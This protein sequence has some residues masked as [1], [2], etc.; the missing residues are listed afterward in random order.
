MFIVPEMHWPI[1]DGLSFATCDVLA[2]AL[3]FAS[4]SQFRFSIHAGHAAGRKSF[5]LA[6]A[7]SSPLLHTQQSTGE[8]KRIDSWKCW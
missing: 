5:L 6:W 4:A 7:S 8:A 2:C 1:L 3:Q